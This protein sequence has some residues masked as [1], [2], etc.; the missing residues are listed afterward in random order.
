VAR[1]VFAADDVTLTFVAPTPEV[2]P[3]SP[4]IYAS[5]VP[6]AVAVEFVSPFPRSPPAIPPELATAL[7]EAVALNWIV[8]VVTSVPPLYARTVGEFVAVER[9]PL[10]AERIEPEDALEVAVAV[11]ALPP[12]TWAAREIFPPAVTEPAPT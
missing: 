5:V 4:E 1:A 12:L 8:P 10:A 6:L 3:T 2:L 11:C 7:F 9:A